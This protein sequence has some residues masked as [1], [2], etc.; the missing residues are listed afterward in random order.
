MF[1]RRVAFSIIC[2]ALVLV[3]VTARSTCHEAEEIGQD[4]NHRRRPGSKGDPG[5]RRIR[6]SRPPHP[7][8]ALRCPRSHSSSRLAWRVARRVARWMARWLV[9]RPLRMCRDRGL[10]HGRVCLTARRFPC[11]LKTKRGTSA[12]KRD[13]SQACSSTDFEFNGSS[14]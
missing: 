13:E 3:L 4:R 10:E 5:S 14:G 1:S 8:R 9:I 2:V 12:L 6:P 11:R 7:P